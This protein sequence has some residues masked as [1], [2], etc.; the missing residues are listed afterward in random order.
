[1]P[2]ELGNYGMPLSLR[3]QQATSAP[4]IHFTM[5]FQLNVYLSEHRLGTLNLWPNHDL[6]LVLWYHDLTL[7]WPY[8]LAA[9]YQF[10]NFNLHENSF[11][12]A[13]LFKQVFTAIFTYRVCCYFFKVSQNI[14]KLQRQLPCC[15]TL[16]SLSFLISCD[17]LAVHLYNICDQITELHGSLWPP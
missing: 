8:L 10:F 3:W 16:C 1:M 11:L 5:Q 13:P 12:L 15:G 6:G 2:T 14:F 17:V 4:G 9:F 7:T